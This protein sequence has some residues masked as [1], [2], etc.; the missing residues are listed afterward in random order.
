VF[1]PHPAADQV[2]PIK[3]LGEILFLFHDVLH[4]WLGCF[5]SLRGLTKS[6]PNTKLNIKSN[7]KYKFKIKAHCQKMAKI[8]ARPR[9]GSPSPQEHQSQLEKWP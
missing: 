1:F 2:K 9:L 3:N 7:S 5:N 8:L 6:K 4:Q